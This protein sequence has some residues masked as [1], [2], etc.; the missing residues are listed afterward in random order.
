MLPRPGLC[1]VRLGWR[2]AW[3]KFAS[4]FLA[5]EFSHSLDPLRAHQR[6]GVVGGHGPGTREASCRKSGTLAILPRLLKRATPSRIG[7]ESG[8]RGR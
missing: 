8:R 5:Q 3:Q 6:I 2:E 1:A 4:T 7:I